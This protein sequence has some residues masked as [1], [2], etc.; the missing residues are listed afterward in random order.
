MNMN[1]EKRF[2][3]SVYEICIPMK[4]RIL[5]AKW[6]DFLLLSLDMDDIEKRSVKYSNFDLKI[7]SYLIHFLFFS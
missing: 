1:N 2:M 7:Y 5:P 3:E 6:V 4:D